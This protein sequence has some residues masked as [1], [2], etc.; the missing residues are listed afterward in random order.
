[1]DTAHENGAEPNIFLSYADNSP[2]HT[3]LFIHGYPL[4]SVMWA[5]QLEGLAGVAYCVAPDLRGFGESGTPG[6]PVSMGDYADDCVALLD[7]LDLVDPVVVCGLSMGGYVALEL[8]RRHP[9]RVAAL[10][11]ASTKAGADSDEAKAGRDKAARTA[12]DEGPEAIAAMMLPKMM[13][14]ATYAEDPDLVA[15]VNE[16][17]RHT[18]V[19]GIVGAL[20]AMR[21]RIDSTPL[22]GAIDVPTLVIHGRDDTLMPLAEGE[23]LAAGIPDAELVVIDDAG[24]LVNL[25][26]ED[27]F[28]EAIFQFLAALSDVLPAD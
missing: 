26:Q 21:D 22:L 17:M 8:Q 25:E 16:I 27:A 1:M 18:G 6:G 14:A 28:N 11:L 12:R 5:P 24:H 3:I 4:S 2:E 20:G 15:D 9:D 23:K 10:I 13:A 7:E 19:E